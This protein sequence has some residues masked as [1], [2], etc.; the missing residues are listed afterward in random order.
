ML[1]EARHQSAAST[2]AERWKARATSLEARLKGASEARRSWMHREAELLERVDERERLLTTAQGGAHTAEMLRTTLL[3]YLERGP[4]SFD[5]FFPLFCAFLDFSLDEQQRLR[6]AHAQHAATAGGGLL[7]YFG[8]DAAAAPAPAI[9]SS[10]AAAAAASASLG[11]STPNGGPRAAEAAAAPGAAAAVDP[12]ALLDHVPRPVAPH[13]AAIAA[14]AA[15]AASATAATADDGESTRVASAASSAVGD[16]ADVGDE[17]DAA[18]PHAPAASTTPRKGGAD[19]DAERARSQR[20][21][22]LLAAADKRLQKAEAELQ[23]RDAEIA[24]LK[25]VAGIPSR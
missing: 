25:L 4:D 6:A 10:A 7:S 17:L 5:E 3:R 2:E 11:P 8:Y 15:A 16:A 19:K 18:P 14:A 12:L 1:A 9:A 23:V 21:K 22:K 13:A 24:A 20:L